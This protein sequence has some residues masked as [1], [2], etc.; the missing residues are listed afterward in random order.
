MAY[1]DKGK[2]LLMEQHGALV[3]VRS[4]YDYN[5]G[6]SDLDD[7]QPIHVSMTLGDYRRIV[8]LIHKAEGQ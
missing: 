7:D 4:G 8:R 2:Q 6:D 3:V 5:P 1:E